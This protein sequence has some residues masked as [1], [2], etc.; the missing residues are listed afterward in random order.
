MKMARRILIS[1]MVLSI[2]ILSCER[3]DISLDTATLKQAIKQSAD[4]LNTAM[5]S[6]GSSKA[7]TLLTVSSP[8]TKS[9]TSDSIYKVYIGL[10]QVK[11]IY[12]YQPVVTTDRLGL[13][14]IQFF[15]KTADDSKMIVR[16]PLKKVEHPRLLREYQVSD[17]SLTNNFLIAVS[18]YHNNYNSYW[19]YDYILTS[20]I[21]IDNVVA[22]N[23][24]IKSIVS[25]TEGTDYKSEYVFAGGYTAQYKYLSGDTTVSSF[26]IL[27]D[28]LLLYEEKRQTVKNDTARFGRE[29]LYILTI[30]N[31]QIIR[32]SGVVAPAIYVDGVLQTSAVVEIIDHESDSEA[33]VCH[34]RD[35][36]ITF[37]DGTTTTISAL[38]GGSVENIKV[39]FDSLHDVYFAAYIVDWIAYDIY[40]K[41]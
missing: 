3:N 13:P 26:G 38:I 7:F 16:L 34:K 9:A 11:G 21:S 15:T 27:K 37:D 6:I 22:G 39:L 35:I 40:Y 1:V 30:G 33:S 25:P 28:N 19:D 17:S 24:N 12:D 20:E 36:Q 29:H 31:I 32:K 5:Q 2:F 18:D 14:L 41:R 4:E 23:L 10:D 8:T